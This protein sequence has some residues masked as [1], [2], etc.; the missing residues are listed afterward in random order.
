M[1]LSG[2]GSISG[3]GSKGSISSSLR[4]GSS[5][6]SSSSS[7]LKSK[8][9][10]K[11]AS[12]AQ[13]SSSIKNRKKSS[14]SKKSKKSSFGWLTPTPSKIESLEKA[15]RE[16]CSDK[17]E[18][19]VAG[20]LDL[21]LSIY[22]ATWNVHDEEG[23]PESL[24]GLVDYP[25]KHVNAYDVYVIGTQEL[26]RTKDKEWERRI[27]MAL[28]PQY[29]MLAGKTLG[30]IHICVFVSKFLRPYITQVQTSS[31]STGIGNVVG[32]KGG[33]GV[34]FNFHKTSF[35]FI[36]SHFAA[37]Q[38]KV[39]ERNEDFRRIMKELSFPCLGPKSRRGTGPTRNF[40]E[41]K[42]FNPRKARRALSDP[43]ACKGLQHCRTS[44]VQDRG[45]HKNKLQFN[46]KDD[47]SDYVD[48]FI[49]MGDLN[50][51]IDGNR[52]VVDSILE[53]EMFEVLRE[54]DQLWAERQ[55]GNVFDPL[56][57]FMEGYIHFKPTYK[58]DIGTNNY[59]SSAK[60]RIP[61]WTDRILFKTTMPHIEGSGCDHSLNQVL[62]DSK[63]EIVFS[64]HK[65]VVSVFKAWLHT[66]ELIA[67]G[68]DKEEKETKEPMLMVT[69]RKSTS[70]EELGKPEAD[71]VAS[72]KA[73]GDRT[74]IRLNSHGLK[75]K[76]EQLSI[77]PDKTKNKSGGPPRHPIFKNNP[78]MSKAGPSSSLC[79]LL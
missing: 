53:K 79:T 64:D 48:H 68:E 56:Q 2:S 55:K 51:R 50:Y 5:R 13:S 34:T 66:D 4:S 70:A 10:S 44:V 67:E 39:K 45:V 59:D 11:S 12:S 78:N 72:S 21:Y 6:K 1:P 49:W 30:Q 38:G 36:S 73:A 35:L 41:G 33:V 40:A 9:S 24:E 52:S 7:S 58:Y 62:Y 31:V 26:P 77:V 29:V 75:K 20:P 8:S 54:N 19:E 22:C 71:A 47:L 65:P 60:A 23:L 61:S 76:L 46:G 43:E 3:E 14:D 63:Q 69:R 17:T 25:R 28:G 37:H 74:V 57:G 27:R 32:N 15:D 16:K 42:D 18:E